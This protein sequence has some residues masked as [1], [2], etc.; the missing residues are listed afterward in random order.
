MIQD[1]KTIRGPR[2]FRMPSFRMPLAR[3][4][5]II[6]LPLSLAGCKH[7]ED[8]GAQVAGWSLI[9][10]EQ[11]HPIMVSQEPAN[12]D[13]RVAPGSQGLS[14]RQRAEVMGFAARYRAGDAGNSRLVIA[15][16]SG[17]PNELA[18]MAA[19]DEIRE[20]LIDGGF[21]EATLAVRAYHDDFSKSPPVRISYMRFVAE[22]PEC[23]QTWE[24]DPIRSY[25]N[26]PSTNL[27]CATQHNL[28]SMVANPADLLGPRSEGPRYGDRRDKVYEGW[29]NGK[30]TG[31]ARS[32]DER[33]QVAR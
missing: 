32:Q 9:D 18:A 6:A 28:A 27:G 8:Q 24:H 17:A 33:V 29:I 22:G 11:R 16:P 21:S 1:T 14:P 25:K 5:A 10:A 20:I 7:L 31:S 23:G 13:V 15:A 30:S 12:L 19:V 26:L 2:S 4:I 3:L